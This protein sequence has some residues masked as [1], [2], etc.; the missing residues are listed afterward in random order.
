MFFAAQKREELA[1]APASDVW[2]SQVSYFRARAPM[3][4][5]PRF[6][7]L[8]GASEKSGGQEGLILRAVSALSPYGVGCR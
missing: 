5:G 6:Q 2:Q 4:G 1:L 7:F 3:D 8:L